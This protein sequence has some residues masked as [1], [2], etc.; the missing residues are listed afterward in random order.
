[1]SSTDRLG[2][3]L[4]YFNGGGRR[5]LGMPDFPD[6]PH[7]QVE[8]ILQGGASSNGVYGVKLFASQHDTIAASLRWTEALPNLKFICLGRRDL[9]GQALSWARA[10]QTLQYRSTQ[11]VERTPVYN[12]EAILGYLQRIGRERARWE[13]FFARTGLA[14]LP[15]IYEDLI[16]DPA[17]QVRR[18][19]EHVG[20]SGTVEIDPKRVDLLMQRDTLSAEWR[21]RFL[22]EH[23]DPDAIDAI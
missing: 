18:V 8:F 16:D 15:V 4:E 10:E 13:V 7:Q 21:E 3:P 11:P 6:D 9:L 1:L 14:P 12:G 5:A 23:G 20:V 19:A 2:Y 17:G 22:R